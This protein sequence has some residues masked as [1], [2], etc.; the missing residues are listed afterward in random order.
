[1]S[2]IELKLSVP[3]KELSKAERILSASAT[4]GR[5]ARR[6]LTSVYYDTPGLDLR[7]RD[8]TLRV[9]R[10]GRR[11]IQ[12]VKSEGLT[13]REPLER[14]EWEDP[15][16]GELPELA[17]NSSGEQLP[18]SIKPDQLRP[19]FSTVVERSLQTIGPTPDTKIEVAA[20]RGEIRANGAAEPI[21]ELELELREG[22]PAALYDAAL[23]IVE[24]LPARLEPRSKSA[25]GYLLAEGAA[26][27]PPTSRV[28]DIGVDPKM[29]VDDA[30]Q[31]IG[32][33]CLA[34]LTAN[35]P[36]V[37]ADCPEGIH[38][39][40]VA[41]RR[42]R[43]I[44]SV[45]RK[46]LP[47]QQYDRVNDELRWLADTAGPARNWDVMTKHLVKPVASAARPDNVDLEALGDRVEHE[48]R[49][50]YERAKAAVRSA[51]FT[52]SLIVV[53]RWFEAREWRQQPVGGKSA[54]LADEIQKVAPDLL[55]RQLRQVRKRGRR[56]AQA[57]AGQRHRLRIALKKLRYSIDF[58][59]SLFDES[60]VERYMGCL[61]RLQD[62][63][64]DANDVR[65]AQQLLGRLD[66]PNQ[67]PEI[68]RAA[69]FVLGW[70]S[71]R[72]AERE[73]V[74]LRQFRKFKRAQPSW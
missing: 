47:R 30:L 43:S 8:L 20:D 26:L 53:S 41:A 59:C 10:E 60:E 52:R 23:K 68:A 39:M 67:P 36:A 16:D 54:R 25:R 6:K 65:V 15:L 46:L 62:E 21:S 7:R 31:A 33:R 74:L 38:Q 58:L 71:E 72:I 64:G 57:G 1:M 35:I 34:A 69:G 18:P 2:E 9:R 5:S 56:L 17:A 66:E 51:R 55:D 28:G 73:H 12:T 24:R 27:K 32:R 45:M 29:T 3:P 37:L 11:F 49:A 22:E 50:A 19:I 4:K 61:K 13:G 44:L 14:R 70:Q 40:R 48:R 63:L 42:L